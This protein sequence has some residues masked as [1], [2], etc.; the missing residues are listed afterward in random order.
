MSRATSANARAP[1]DPNATSANNPRTTVNSSTA[2]TCRLFIPYPAFPGSM[3]PI[4]SNAARQ[5]ATRVSSSQSGVGPN[6]R[7]RPTDDSYHRTG[8]TQRR[9]SV[10]PHGALHTYAIPPSK[11]H[12]LARLSRFGRPFTQGTARP[13]STPSSKHTTNTCTGYV[14][15]PALYAIH[16]HAKTAWMRLVAGTARQSGLYVRSVAIGTLLLGAGAHIAVIVLGREAQ[17][18]ILTPGFELLLTVPMFYVGVAGWLAWRTFVFL[19][20]W[21]QVVLALILIYFPVGIPFHLITV[22]TGSTAHYAVFP[23]QYS[24]LIVP[25]MTAFIAC[26]AGLRVRANQS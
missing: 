1:P 6:T 26:F 16:A 13:T 25:V 14:A 11:G 12:S 5:I 24:L 23:E 19:G 3:A 20:R 9:A 8:Y 15:H 22:T 4:A 10:L 18:R 2:C 21:H 17:P 7:I